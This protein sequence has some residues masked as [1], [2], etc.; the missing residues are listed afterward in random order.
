MCFSGVLATPPPPTGR[1]FGC[2]E[3]DRNPPASNLFDAARGFRVNSHIFPIIGYTRQFTEGGNQ[4]T[5]T[6][7]LPQTLPGL[8]IVMYPRDD[9]LEDPL[10]AG[11]CDGVAG[12]QLGH[13]LR[14]QAVELIAFQHL[15]VRGAWVRVWVSP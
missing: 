15:S 10:L 7:I 9:T 3:R 11:N 8:N 4:P 5:G 12:N 14:S 6:G 13:L 1:S 2:D